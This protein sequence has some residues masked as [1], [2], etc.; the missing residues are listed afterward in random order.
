MATQIPE[1]LKQSVPWYVKI[2]LKCAIS[3]LP[4][5]ERF[6][7]RINLFRAGA[8]DNPETALDTLKFFLHLVDLTDLSGKTVL[9]L[10]PGNSLLTAFFAASLGTERTWLI[11]AKP[12]A[13]TDVSLFAQAVALLE[14]KGMPLL[15]VEGAKSNAEVMERLRATY[16]TDGLVSLTKVPSASVDFVFSSAVL[17][18]IRLHEFPDLLKHL[19]RIIK[20]TGVAAH[21]IDFRDHLQSGLNNLRFTERVWESSFMANSGFY[22]NRIPWPQMSQMFEKSGFSVEAK[23]LQFWPHGLPTPQA[24]MAMPYRQMPADDFRVY[25]SHVVLRPQLL[26]TIRSSSCQ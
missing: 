18:H 21:T 23:Q 13:E 4:F 25:L 2:P 1:S 17:E 12:L 19:R 6:W 11:D 14:A 20:P 26:G 24:K 9:E 3:R 10:G 16:E 15:D 5:G 7:Q 22:T 8:M